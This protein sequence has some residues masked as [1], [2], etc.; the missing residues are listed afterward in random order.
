L[1]QDI[2][3]ADALCQWVVKELQTWTKADYIQLMHPPAPTQRSTVYRDPP[4][5]SPYRRIRIPVL[6]NCLR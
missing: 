3:D 4:V 5:H 2:V 6:F 1:R